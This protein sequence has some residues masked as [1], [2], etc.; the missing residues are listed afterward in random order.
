ML[1]PAGSGSVRTPV[2]RSAS[3]ACCT[4]AASM[5]AASSG[6]SRGWSARASG[7][8]SGVRVRKSQTPWRSGRASARRGG[9]N[10]VCAAAGGAMLDAVTRRTRTTEHLGL[11]IA[12]STKPP[13]DLAPGAALAVAAGRR[14]GGPEQRGG[15]A[16][17][18]GPMGG[19]PATAPSS[20]TRRP[21]ARHP[22]GH[23]LTPRRLDRP[24]PEGGA[25]PAAEIAGGNVLLTARGTGSYCSSR[26]LENRTT[27]E[28]RST[29]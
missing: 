17:P 7:R 29:W 12:C 26:W 25:A 8:S 13:G 20:A 28:A 18:H 3:M 22:R 15:R 11:L 21:G 14:S 6:V 4:A 2:G 9:W 10:R 23:L 16:L 5:A 27:F 19:P 24:L 1:P